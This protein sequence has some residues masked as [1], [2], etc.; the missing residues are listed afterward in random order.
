MTWPVAMAT[1]AVARTIVTHY[2]VYYYIPGSLARFQFHD[3]LERREL[4]KTNLDT[5]RD[6]C[7]DQR[8][9]SDPRAGRPRHPFHP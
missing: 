9:R 6:G 8:L 4:S 3:L 1:N 5:G 2:P 7:L